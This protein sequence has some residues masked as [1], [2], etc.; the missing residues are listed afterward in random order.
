MLIDPELLKLATPE[1]LAAYE[2]ELLREKALL[3]PLDYAIYTTDGRMKSYRHTDL[4]SRYAKALCE[5]ALYPEGI[6]PPA[7]WDDEAGIWKHPETG[8]EAVNVLVL[9][10]PPQ[11]GKSYIVTETVPAWFLTKHPDKRVIV[12][13]Y[14]SEFAKNFGRA[15]RDK[16]EAA[17]E[18]G[19]TVSKD[20]RAADNWNIEGTGGGLATAG[21][22]GP[23]SG[24]R[25]DLMIID[26]PVKNQDDALSET[27]R[28]RN[29]NWWESVV[30]ARM[31]NDS[32]IIVIQTRWHEDDLAGHIVRT[33]RCYELNLP[34][35][36]FEDF[37][38]KETGVSLDPDTGKPD[39][40]GRKP[41]E[42]LC[43]ELQSRAVLLRKKDGG[44]IGD[45]PGGMVW[46]TALYQG[47][48]NIQ[49]GGIF[50]RPYRYFTVETNFSGRKFY[51]IKDSKTHLTKVYLNECV[52]FITCDLATSVRTTADFTVFSLWAYTPC[53]KLL[54]VDMFRERIEGPYHASE[55]EKFWRSS[56]RL[57]D[58]AGVRFFGV[59]SKT[60]G[61]GLISSLR[62]AGIPVKPLL[63]DTDKVAR[64]LPVGI[65]LK[66]DRLYLPRDADFLPVLEKEMQGFPNTKHDDMV[67]TMGYAVSEAR[68]LPVTQ[69]KAED[70]PNPHEVAVFMP[71]PRQTEH[72]IVGAW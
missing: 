29:K 43:P 65:W 2:Q 60:F 41:G 63:A 16:I 15:N 9:S 4:M 55:A 3:S 19:V 21:S 23:I 22:G 28:R 51:Q 18:L 66:E 17:P 39:P 24:K 57:T 30:K 13:G 52:Y 31:R 7:V 14:E 33:E 5:H 72:P 46:F 37:A 49:G 45:E 71:R 27:A 58:G 44:D 47:K 6:G 12:A 59:E 38:D 8:V 68:Y 70:E 53:G 11:H 20:S 69:R 32:V 56:R 67:D 42:A 40:L 61:L 48:P 36:A 50:P 35:L 26:D 64:A 10:I 1:E 62:L 34:A 54:L 25:M